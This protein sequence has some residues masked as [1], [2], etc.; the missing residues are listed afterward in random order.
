MGRLAVV[1]AALAV[2]A[3]CGGGG[4]PEATPTV[5]LLTR[6]HIAGARVVFGFRS[7][8]TAV[9]TRFSKPSAVAESGSG[10]H[11]PVRGATV[12]I[13]SFTPSATA[14]IQGE[15]VVRT[16]T[17][18]KRVSGEGAVTEAVKVGDFESQ[19]D[20]AIGLDSRRP[21]RVERDGAQ[22]AVVFGAR[23]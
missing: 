10:R 6:V 23:P 7:A 2:V 1:L 20:W 18:P 9:A 14:E 21:V 19:L 3:G 12:L 13:V 15:K 8:P 5:A 22:V 16:Y 4:K 17:G 11:V